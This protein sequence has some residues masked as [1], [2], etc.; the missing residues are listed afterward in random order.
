MRDIEANR[1]VIDLLMDPVRM[2]NRPVWV[3]Q[4]PG[5]GSKGGETIKL[6]VGADGQPIRRSGKRQ[7]VTGEDGKDYLVGSAQVMQIDNV[8]PENVVLSPQG[9]NVVRLARLRMAGEATAREAQARADAQ[10]RTDAATGRNVQGRRD[11]RAAAPAPVG[12]QYGLNIQPE[13]APSTRGAQ[14]EGTVRP[15]VAQ[16]VA[17]GA[18]TRQSDTFNADDPGAVKPETMPSGVAHEPLRVPDL[19]EQEQLELEGLTQTSG[20]QAVAR[21]RASETMTAARA[22][23]T[24]K[25]V[26]LEEL[27]GE[28]RQKLDMSAIRSGIKLPES[29]NEQDLIAAGMAPAEAADF[30]LAID[31][32]ANR[33]AIGRAADHDAAATPPKRGIAGI[34]EFFADL[35]RRERRAIRKMLQHFER[36]IGPSLSDLDIIDFANW[37]AAAD[38]T[39]RKQGKQA[40]F[41]SPDHAAAYIPERTRALADGI[42]RAA[43]A[44]RSENATEASKAKAIK[45]LAHELTHFMV[46]LT[47]QSDAD[48]AKLWDKLSLNMQNDPIYQEVLREYGEDFPPAVLGH[49]FLA[50]KMAA[51]M[52]GRYETSFAKLKPGEDPG[53]RTYI[54]EFI[55]RALQ[56]VADA[57]DWVLGRDIIH[58]VFGDIAQ[59]LQVNLDTYSL[60]RTEI[61]PKTG[62][63]YYAVDD[64]VIA[65]KLSGDAGVAMVRDAALSYYA[66]NFNRDRKRMHTAM[67]EEFGKRWTDLPAKLR[68]AAM[69]AGIA[70]LEGYTDLKLIYKKN[71]L[72]GAPQNPRAFTE[73]FRMALKGEGE[74]GSG[75]L[76]YELTAEEFLARFGENAIT[77]LKHISV[78]SPQ[79]RV[80]PNTGQ[81]LN[82]Y[83][84]AL[85][86]PHVP[87]GAYPELGISG[88]GT[89]S[90]A[91]MANALKDTGDWSKTAKKTQSF[92]RALAEDLDLTGEDYTGVV[93]RWMM[94]AFGFNTDNPTPG[95]YVHARLIMRTMADALGWKVK[96]VQAAIWCAIKLE[97][98]NK[99]DHDVRNYGDFVKL[100]QAALNFEIRPSD[101]FAVGAMFSSLSFRDQQDITATVVTALFPDLLRTLNL[102][103]FNPLLNVGHGGFLGAQSPSIETRVPMPDFGIDT[104]AA[105]IGLVFRQDSVLVTRIEGYGA[106]IQNPTAFAAVTFLDQKEITDGTAKRLWDHIMRV[107]PRLNGGYALQG[108]KILFFNLQDIEAKALRKQP[109][110][111]MT[112]EV[113]NAAIKAAIAT[114]PT[115]RILASRRPASPRRG[116]WATTGRQIPMARVISMP[117]SAFGLG[118]QTTFS[119]NGRLPTRS[120]PASSPSADL[121]SRPKARSIRSVGPLPHQYPWVDPL[122]SETDLPESLPPKT[123]SRA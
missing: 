34:M 4:R 28:I 2:V 114:Y 53:L 7:Q 98:P 1:E 43:I 117:L 8:A 101:S 41:S 52:S 60:V 112:D 59:Q 76:W 35:P 12:T 105:A 84:Q 19:T 116:W 102:Q 123:N 121:N 107:D 33:D 27:P 47:G 23:L 119:L 78:T 29:F 83:T 58:T 44:L 88:I 42:Q 14:A 3:L 72:I 55:R 68:S 38:T 5:K 24:P 106:Y 86:R 81:G 70:R 64:E 122:T 90:V 111:K 25:R 108:N 48:M 92:Y 39:L 77:F 82:S 11:P 13:G 100:E 115:T 63:V 96:W 69:E 20:E 89:P 120:S 18:A 9:Q 94:R 21:S 37:A 45:L 87:I 85:L 104:L 62:E 31:R 54:R 103:D 65:K 99:L 67:V 10:E 109:L 26:T 74:D 49:E 36:H 40:R 6:A 17:E 80:G 97:S 30:F 71:L 113:F 61:D 110:S 50:H 93:D 51:A 118:S 15:E 57:F 16:A 22:T 32:A 95:Q 73:L 91:I 46:G 56:F 75:K 66:A 79:N